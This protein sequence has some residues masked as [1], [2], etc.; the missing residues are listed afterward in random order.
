MAV[1]TWL[2]A[3]WA[4]LIG[5]PRPGNEMWMLRDTPRTISRLSGWNHP[6][7]I[8][9]R[10]ANRSHRQNSRILSSTGGTRRWCSCGG[11]IPSTRLKISGLWRQRTTP[12][13][14]PEIPGIKAKSRTSSSTIL[15]TPGS[16]TGRR[17]RQRH[18]SQSQ[19]P[20]RRL[21]R[22][23]GTTG[24]TTGSPPGSRTRSRRI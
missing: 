10:T 2:R 4:E 13:Q 16:S 17:A 21:S 23:P 12:G 18:R 6:D 14:L 1:H 8:P 20:G 24:T 9:S 15:T 5:I 11:S 22:S 19:L 3:N 7:I